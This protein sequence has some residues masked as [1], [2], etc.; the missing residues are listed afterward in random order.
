MESE[1]IRGHDRMQYLEDL[2]AKERTDRIESLES[3][4]VPVR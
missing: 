2:L 3:Q 4:L 1:R